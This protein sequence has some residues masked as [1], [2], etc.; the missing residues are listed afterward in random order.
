[1]IP[2]PVSSE[3]APY[4]FT[5]IDQVEGSDPMA[6]LSR[7]LDELTPWLSQISEEQ[8][9]HRYAPGKWSMR[10]VLNHITD[11]ER[12]F[13]FR[14]LWFARGFDAPLPG[15]DQEIAAA[16]AEAD[17]FTWSSHVEDFRS[18]RLSTIALF[19]NLPPAAWSR[20][21][22]ASGNPFTVR[23]LAYIIPGHV[24]HHARI[25]RERYF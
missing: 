18:V 24:A 19:G 13:A 5:Y 8:S 4:Y 7:Q 21:G 12:A 15:Y 1:V 16:G 20:T 6:V 14:A 9:L 2:R 17:A 10:Q 3:V 11:T 22:I 25:L 23:A